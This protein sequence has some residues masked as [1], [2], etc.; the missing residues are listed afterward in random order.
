MIAESEQPFAIFKLCLIGQGGVGKTC[1]AKRLCFD[2]FDINTTL[3]IGIN[4][5]SYKIPIL[6]KEG[7]ES[8]VTLSIWDFGGQEQFKRLFPY[9]IN[10]ANGILAIFSVAEISTLSAL[11]WWYSKLIKQNQ[12]DTP[13]ILIGAKQD[14][15]GKKEAQS[16]VDDLVIQRFMKRHNETRFQRTSSKD[17]VNIGKVFREMTEILLKKNE[18]EYERLL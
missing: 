11:E 13:R 10:G 15:I 8:F 3:T 9:Y 4:F 14:L 6:V 18:F 7:E 16:P 1:I 5:N 17:D 2:S 12:G